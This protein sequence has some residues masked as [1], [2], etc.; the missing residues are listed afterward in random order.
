MNKKLL[1]IF[2]LVL[3]VSKLF[4]ICIAYDDI[5]EK[6]TYD[7]NI[8]QKVSKS[9]IEQEIELTGRAW[10]YP[11]LYSILIIPTLFY[12][13][14]DYLIM[15]NIIFIAI[16]YCFLVLFCKIFVSE[17]KAFVISFF[18]LFFDVAFSFTHLGMPI[19]LSAM[20]FAAFMYNMYK[21]K[22]NFACCS[23]SFM[24]L[25]LTKYLFIAL[26]PIIIY[27]IIIN[28]KPKHYIKIVTYFVIPLIYVS[29]WIFRNMYHYGI[30]IRGAIGGYSI[31]HLDM[32][33]LP[34][35]TVFLVTDY[36]S[37][38]VMLI[39]LLFVVSVIFIYCICTCRKQIRFANNYFIFNMLLLAYFIITF[40]MFGFL[41]EVNGFRIRYFSYQTIILMALAIINIMTICNLKKM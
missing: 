10:Q 29:S 7:F 4:I 38:H 34:E 27:W 21:I 30:S 2:L 5:T 16:T 41:Y 18:I 37:I 31:L 13:T 6:N 40:F 22:T 24:L 8:Y 1:L 15:L 12:D 17:N 14:T 20:L 28:Y 25:I 19:S 33:L 9:L 35:K 32:N 3:M 11:P 36:Y 26:V 39:Y 23:V